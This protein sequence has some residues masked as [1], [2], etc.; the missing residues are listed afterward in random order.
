MRKVSFDPVVEVE[1]HPP[2]DGVPSGIT[3]ERMAGA[4][5][6]PPPPRANRSIDPRARRSCFGQDR[7]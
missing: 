7:V 2:V 1:S 3:L 4:A 5:A 6:P